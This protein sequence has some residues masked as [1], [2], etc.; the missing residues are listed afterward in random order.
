[1]DPIEVT[2][3]VWNGE[4]FTVK[5]DSTE[6]IDDLKDKIQDLHKIPVEQQRL[7]FEG[8]PVDDACTL[9]EQCIQDKSRLKLEPLELN[10]K[11]PNKKS[12]TLTVAPDFTIKKLKRHI[13]RK[14]K[15]YPVD[16]QVIRHNGTQLNNKKTIMESG[17]EHEDELI[18]ELFE[19]SAMHWEGEL[20]TIQGLH[21][22]DTLQR[23]QKIVQQQEG[24]EAQ[25]QIYLM[26][27]KR[28]NSVTSLKDQRIQHMATLTMEKPVIQKKREKF[29]A[30]VF[31]K[32]IAMQSHDPQSTCNSTCG[33]SVGTSLM[34]DISI[35]V[36]VSKNE[37]FALIIDATEFVDKTLRMD[38]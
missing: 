25:H 1:M 31:E 30:A 9:E 24:I 14:K 20:F 3:T 18:M 16:L 35:D 37:T 11:L 28:L 5:L 13:A 22:N 12:L 4:T 17:L 2:I 6:Y 8:A 34:G 27:E 38:P 7:Y 36:K 29:K 21:P 33:S 15:A 23:L 10:V 19:I 26:G 32:P